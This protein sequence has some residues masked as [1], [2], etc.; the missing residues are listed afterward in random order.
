MLQNPEAATSD[1][2]VTEARRK[3]HAPHLI[4]SRARPQER[5]ASFRQKGIS[6]G[7]FKR[8]AWPYWHSRLSTLERDV[9]NANTAI[10]TL[11]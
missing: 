7:V 6:P 2:K 5:Q 11:L 4:Q 3:P 1:R 8:L 10:A 9:P